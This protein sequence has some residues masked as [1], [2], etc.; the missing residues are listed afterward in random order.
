MP[1]INVNRMPG[2]PV[3]AQK[4]EYGKNGETTKSERLDN[5]MTRNVSLEHKTKRG[6]RR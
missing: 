2:R 6:T 5:R 4:V 1:L 3:K